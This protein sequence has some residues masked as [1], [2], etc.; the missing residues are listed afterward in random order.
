MTDAGDGVLVPVTHSTYRMLQDLQRLH[1]DKAT[2]GA[3]LT[4]GE[5]LEKA[6]AW[7]A[8]MTR[9]GSELQYSPPGARPWASYTRSLGLDL[10]PRL[11]AT[12]EV[13]EVLRVDHR[14]WRRVPLLADPVAADGLSLLDQL[15]RLFAE[16]ALRRDDDWRVASINPPNPAPTS[17][18]AA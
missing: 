15:V 8:G 14:A 10:T 9:G 5:V 3:R 16:Q 7:Y 11:V 4:T 13:A 1:N 12:A 18:D 17:G 2:G 6:L